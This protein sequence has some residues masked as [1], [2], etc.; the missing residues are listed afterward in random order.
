M[1]EMPGCREQGVYKAPRSNNQLHDYRWLCLDHIREHNEKWD[2]FHGMN[3]SEIE[4]FMRDAI[5]GHRPTWNRETRLREPVANLHDALY[6]FLSGK[7]KAKKPQPQLST[8]IRKALALL[9]LEYPFDSRQLKRRYREM[10]KKYHPD[11]NKTDK[12]AEDKFKKI[13]E[14]YHLLAAH[15]KASMYKASP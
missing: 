3:A 11:I 10:V 6:E 12:L 14:S 8:K 15:L 13:T 1:C 2:Y 7:T 5:T 4:A 9:D